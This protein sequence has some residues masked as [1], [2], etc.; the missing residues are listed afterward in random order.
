MYS[1]DYY[2]LNF[3]M[4]EL[5]SNIWNFSCKLNSIA[6]QYRTN[7]QMNTYF[8]FLRRSYL[9]LVGYSYIYNATISENV[10]KSFAKAT[11]LYRCP[12]PTYMTVQVEWHKLYIY[13]EIKATL[14]IDFNTRQEHFSC[15]NCFC[16]VYVEVGCVE[17]EIRSPFQIARQCVYGVRIVVWTDMVEKEITFG[18]ISQT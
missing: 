11:V 3:V 10:D 8:I 16:F 18:I 15:L 6:F 14:R 5:L 12:Q 1:L 2:R 7:I 9:I 13:G 17:F 4:V